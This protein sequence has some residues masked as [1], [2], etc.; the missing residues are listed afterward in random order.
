M[1]PRKGISWP[2]VCYLLGEA[3]YGGR[4]TDDFDKTLLVTFTQLWFS[5]R[6]LQPAFEFYYG[7]ALPNPSQLKTTQGIIEY[8]SQLPAY[9][10]PQVLGLH[11]NA[12]ITF[13]INR[14][15][16]I[17]NVVLSIQPKEGGSSKGGETRESVVYKLAAD[18]LNKMPKDFIDFEVK[19]ALNRLGPLLPMTI[20]LRQEIARIQ[21]VIAKV[22][23]EQIATCCQYRWSSV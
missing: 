9:D 6:I 18:M 15:Q 12:D 2:T 5:D 11:S 22:M 23:D 20:F 16:S 3:Q 8:V 14:A 10:S 1:D 13:Q 19:E 7:Y 4:V 21:R 17:L